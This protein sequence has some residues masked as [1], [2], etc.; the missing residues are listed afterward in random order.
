MDL[1]SPNLRQV[2]GT[3]THKWGFLGFH[4]RHIGYNRN[5]W[6]RKLDTIVFKWWWAEQ[7]SVI[8]KTYSADYFIFCKIILLI[9]LSWFLFHNDLWHIVPLSHTKFDNHISIFV[10]KTPL[11][12]C[13]QIL[14]LPKSNLKQQPLTNPLVEV[15]SCSFPHKYLNSFHIHSTHAIPH[16]SFPIPSPLLPSGNILDAITEQELCC[17]SSKLSWIL[18]TLF[19]C[20]N[21]TGQKYIFHWCFP[22]VTIQTTYL[23]E[24]IFC[25][26]VIWQLSN[27]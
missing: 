4:E 7:Y 1:T 17:T 13:P 18:G 25:P 15:T 9:F 16:S 11:N 22:H 3:K 12:Q 24:C 19:L 10:S 14:H 23:S 26:Q 6:K 21:A 20:H 8:T 27:Q 5:I 2:G